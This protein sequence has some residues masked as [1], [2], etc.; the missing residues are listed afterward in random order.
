MNDRMT[1]IKPVH[2]RGDRFRA[3]IDDGVQAGAQELR[4][5]F[6]AGSMTGGIQ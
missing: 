1:T 3:V 6:H 4:L 5:G 2:E